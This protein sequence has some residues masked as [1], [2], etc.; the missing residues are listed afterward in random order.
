MD[1]AYLF[2]AE[3]PATADT[4]ALIAPCMNMDVMEKH[5]A[6]IS[7]KVPEGCHA[8][9]VVD[10]AAWYQLHLTDKFDN[11]TIIK[12]PSYSPELNPMEKV[13]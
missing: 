11:L 8:V 4:E 5:L 3:C 7:K 13:W 6:L 9:I 1:Y 12:L 2:G 10:G